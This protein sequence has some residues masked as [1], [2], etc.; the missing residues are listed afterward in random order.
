MGS[1]AARCAPGRGSIGA[2]DVVESDRAAP[3]R[4]RYLTRF[5]DGRFGDGGSVGGGGSA[6]VSVPERVGAGLGLRVRAVPLRVAMPLLPARRGPRGA[7]AGASTLAGSAA[8]PP[9]ASLGIGNG[10][11]KAGYA[12][13]LP[14][15][16]IGNAIPWP[17]SRA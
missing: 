3:G 4:D 17:F 7:A 8:S 16:G 11:V 9:L 15:L 12:I 5:S 14:S 1:G 10:V 13:A 6:D 2:G